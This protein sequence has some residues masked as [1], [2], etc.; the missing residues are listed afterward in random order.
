MRRLD[1]EG[2]NESAPPVSNPSWTGDPPP[3]ATPPSDVSQV[4]RQMAHGLDGHATVAATAPFLGM[5]ATIFGIIGSFRRCAPYLSCMAALTARLSASIAPAAEGLAVAIL[6][7]TGRKHFRFRLAD[8]DIEMDHAALRSHESHT[9]SPFAVTI[10]C[11]PPSPAD[12]R[13]GKSG[14]ERA[15]RKHPCSHPPTSASTKTPDEPN[16]SP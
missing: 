15:T 1:A 2:L 3:H 6:A 11:L 12:P 9:D 14:G 5:F 7:S 16:P 13:R 10:F 8:F 4:Y